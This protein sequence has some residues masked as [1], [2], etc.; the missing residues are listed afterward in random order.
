VIE[1]LLKKL[2]AFE[3]TNGFTSKDISLG[4][5]A[6]QLHTNKTHLS[7]VINEHKQ[8]TW[9]N[10]LKTLRINYITNLM[11]SN[12]LYLN[13]NIGVLGEM[14]GYK[15]RQQFSKQFFEIHDLPP[16]DFIML[17]KKEKKQ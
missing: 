16:A 8:M 5:L 10:Y 9:P 12:P 13:Y 2:E 4:S 3:N 11:L 7:Y 6:Q 14:C 15:S 1:K 17:R